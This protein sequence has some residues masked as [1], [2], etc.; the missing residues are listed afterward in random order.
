M[1]CLDNFSVALIISFVLYQSR[2]FLLIDKSDINLTAVPQNGDKKVTHFILGRN[3]IVQIDNTSFPLY[4]KLRFLEMDKNPLKYI[5]ENSFQN[6]PLLHFFSCKF[7]KIEYLP[8]NF[9]PCTPSFRSFPMLGGISRRVTDSIFSY[10][11]F[12]AFTS[13]QLITLRNLPLNSMAK[14]EL[15]P[16]LEKVVV[17]AA[18]LTTFPNLTSSNFPHLTYLGMEMNPIN[19]IPENVW[20]RLSD[21]LE[22]LTMFNTGLSVMVDL[23]LKPNLQEIDISDNHLET[24]PDL[25]NMTSLSILKIAGNSRMAC[26]RRMCWRRIWDR[27]R[28]PLASSDDVTCVQ[29][30]VLAG[31]KLSVVNPKMMECEKGMIFVFVFS[32]SKSPEF[33]IIP[34]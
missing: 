12:R 27:I 24:V 17:A 22:V 15:P 29:P 30:P 11:Y 2:A 8:A 6:N 23:T 19:V 33:T 1:K 3:L 7:C 13:L 32:T 20:E 26:D 21:K 25:L 28:A 5:R 14:L 4:T 9:G 31:Y 10:P 18:N 34:E 16:S